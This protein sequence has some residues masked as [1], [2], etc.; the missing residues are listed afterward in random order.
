MLDEGSSTF[1]LVGGGHLVGEDSILALLRRAGI[2]PS[3]VT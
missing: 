2:E 3:R 1:V